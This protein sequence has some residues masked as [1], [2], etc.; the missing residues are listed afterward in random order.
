[1]EAKYKDGRYEAY[2]VDMSKSP[3]QTAHRIEKFALEVQQ[4]NFYKSALYFIL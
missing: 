4:E 1:M 2:Q 3:E